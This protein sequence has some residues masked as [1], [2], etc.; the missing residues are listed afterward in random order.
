[1]FNL[2]TFAFPSDTKSISIC[3]CIIQRV[4]ETIYSELLSARAEYNRQ[5]LLARTKK[6]T[7]MSTGVGGLQEEADHLLAS[8]FGFEYLCLARVKIDAANAPTG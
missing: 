5:N 7:E 8:D 6:L 1:M 2:A 4:L 3:L